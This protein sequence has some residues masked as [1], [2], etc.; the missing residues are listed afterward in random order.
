MKKKLV[1][2]S[3]RCRVQRWRFRSKP[4]RLSKRPLRVF[5]EVDGA[6]DQ[7]T[8]GRDRPRREDQRVRVPLGRGAAVWATKTEKATNASAK[9]ASPRRLSTCIAATTRKID[10]VLPPDL[11]VLLRVARRR[12]G[13]EQRQ[14]AAGPSRPRAPL[15]P[16]GPSRPRAA[17][18]PPRSWLAVAA[19]GSEVDRR[20]GCPQSYRPRAAA[21]GA[22]HDRRRAAPESGP[23]VDCASAFACFQTRDLVLVDAAPRCPGPPT[24]ADSRPKA[25]QPCAPQR[26]AQPRPVTAREAQFTEEWVATHLLGPEAKLERAATMPDAIADGYGVAALIHATRPDVLESLHAYRVPGSARYF[27]RYFAVRTNKLLC[28]RSG[29]RQRFDAAKIIERRPLSTAGTN[30][31][32]PRARGTGA[33]CGSARYND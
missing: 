1:R 20:R 27:A 12:D 4:S 2:S 28:A 5:L 29:R 21:R 7:Y 26:M 30:A 18:A 10:D 33:C 17:S 22:D 31:A 25:A 14:D 24:R 23:P 32:A 16:S 9:A 3:S 15:A 19:R 6:P 13:G 11:V 8:C